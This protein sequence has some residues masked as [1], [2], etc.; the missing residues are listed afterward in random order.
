V[1]LHSRRLINY[2]VFAFGSGVYLCGVDY[3]MPFLFGF[4]LEEGG[5]DLATVFDGSSD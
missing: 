1:Q 3:F 5:S 2:L 4:S